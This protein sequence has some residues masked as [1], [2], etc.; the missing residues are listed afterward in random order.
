[1]GVVVEIPGV[2]VQG[3]LDLQGGG[4]TLA[5]IFSQRFSMDITVK[6]TEPPGGKWIV[7]KG[8]DT[9]ERPHSGA[10]GNHCKTQRKVSE[11]AR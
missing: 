9:H 10:E 8:G 7:T 5:A 6:V 1:M 3:T 2:E 4:D 11:S